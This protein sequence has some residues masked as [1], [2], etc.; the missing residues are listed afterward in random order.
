MG[1]T[2]ITKRAR[3]TVLGAIRGGGG[4]LGDD[5]QCGEVH[6]EHG[7]VHVLREGGEPPVD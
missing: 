4:I 2:D 3:E 1:K 5:A 6:V 7:A